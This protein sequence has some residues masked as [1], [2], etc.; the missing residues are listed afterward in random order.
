LCG[1]PQGLPPLK[2]SIGLPPPKKYGGKKSAPGFK[3]GLFPP[4]ETPEFEG[5]K[6]GFIKLPEID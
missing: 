4:W 6:R 2:L 5:P 1:S 3:R